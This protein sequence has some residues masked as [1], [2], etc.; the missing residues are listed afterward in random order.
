[1]A[2]R[3]EAR[4]YLGPPENHVE[5]VSEWVSPKPERLRHLYIDSHPA[6]V[7]ICRGRYLPCILR[8]LH[9]FGKNLEAEE[10]RDPGRVLGRM[11]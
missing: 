9:S 10:Q 7:E 11:P 5:C 6:V 1:M 4:S 2:I 8:A 3:N